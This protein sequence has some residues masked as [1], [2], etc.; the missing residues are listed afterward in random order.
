MSTIVWPIFYSKQRI[1]ESSQYLFPADE[2]EQ[3][4]FVQLFHGDTWGETF[5][6]D[7]SAV[8]QTESPAPYNCQGLRWQTCY[9]SSVFK[10]WRPRSGHWNRNRSA[11]RTI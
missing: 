5:D 6:A 7:L 9:G 11:N 1:S 4:R 10:R 2:G 3:E 8:I